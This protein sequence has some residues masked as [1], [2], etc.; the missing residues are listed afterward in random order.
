LDRA[1]S[2]PDQTAVEYG[3]MPAGLINQK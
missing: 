2:K 1:F 3:V